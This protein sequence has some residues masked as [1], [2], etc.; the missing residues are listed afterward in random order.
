MGLPPVP[1]DRRP[2]RTLIDGQASGLIAAT[3]RGL[4]Y[5]DGIFTTLRVQR[6]MPVFLEDHLARLHR[7]AAQLFLPVPATR[8]LRREALALA[9]ELGDGVLKILW[10]RGPGGRGYQ[11][12]DP[13]IPCRILATYAMPDYPAELERFGVGVG[14]S[15]VR[16]G[17]NEALAG[18]KHL[19]RLEQVLARREWD[20]GEVREA[21]MRDQADCVVE[22][23][24]SNLFLV[25]GGRLVTPLLDRCGVRG[26]MRQRVLRVAA[27]LGIECREGR[28]DLAAVLGADE[29]FLSNSLIGIWPVAEL[30]GRRF[31]V[32]PLTSLLRDRLHEQLADYLDA[33]CRA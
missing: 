12:P 18:A 11:C 28:F 2:L 5:G 23:V 13:A 26:V 24:M 6:G 9:G 25:Q 22:G 21:L 3:D 32:G 16:L 19:N 10:T 4:Q 17:H 20:G 30:A 14:L 29:V 8:M 31:P 27:E 33:A 1:G 15:S 7:D